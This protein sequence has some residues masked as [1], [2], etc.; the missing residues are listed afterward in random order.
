[1]YD[2]K[3]QIRE[4]EY[5]MAASAGVYMHFSQRN[6]SLTYTHRVVYSKIRQ[7]VQNLEPF[8]VWFGV[9]FCMNGE[10]NLCFLYKGELIK[11]NV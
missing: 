9:Y 1:M 11:R 5:E 8:P 4:T 7:M 10:N 3:P 2:Y 6:I